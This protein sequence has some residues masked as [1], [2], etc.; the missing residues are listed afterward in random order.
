[1]IIQEGEGKCRNS[2]LLGTP[3]HT[4]T[5]TKIPYDKIWLVQ[6]EIAE[7]LKDW[8]FLYYFRTQAC[9]YSFQRLVSGLGYVLGS[10]VCRCLE[11]R[12]RFTIRRERLTL[13]VGS[14]WL[15]TF[16]ASAVR[17]GWHRCP[18][19]WPVGQAGQMTSASTHWGNCPEPYG[20][21]SQSQSRHTGFHLFALPNAEMTYLLAHFSTA[22][23]S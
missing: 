21:S 9:T 3:H 20:S 7:S 13:K 12:R 19:C 4:H 10:L 18:C 6:E 8:S 1:M 15:V 23:D 11:L 2:F 17:L 16:T 14:L 22:E 5:H